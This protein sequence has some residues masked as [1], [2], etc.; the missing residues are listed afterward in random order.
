MEDRGAATGI[1]IMSYFMIGLKL[2]ITYVVIPIPLTMIEETLI[3]H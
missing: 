1:L 2:D 3:D